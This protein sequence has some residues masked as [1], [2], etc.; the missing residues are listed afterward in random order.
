MQQGQREGRGLA[1]TGLGN[2]QKVAPL[3]YGGDGLGLDRGGGLVALILQGL[4]DKRVEAQ[5][6]ETIGHDES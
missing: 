3:Q 4:Q 6:L 5:R 2:A 1:G